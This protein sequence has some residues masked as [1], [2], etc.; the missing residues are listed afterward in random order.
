MNFL[1]KW[2]HIIRNCS[3]DNT[4]KMAWAKAITEISLE[5]DYNNE[6]ESI[7]IT[8]EQI[9]NKVL[10][11]YWEQTIYF[12]LI[13][14]S[15]PNKP[16]KI[17]SFTKELIDKYQEKVG[18]KKPK[19]FYKSMVETVCK[20]DYKRTIGKIVTGLKQDVSYRFLNLG[21]ENIESVYRYNRGDDKLV[22]SKDNLLE[23][24]RNYQIVFDTINYRWT[25]I[26]E[27]FN[28]SPR[29]SKKIKVIDLDEVKRR[30]LGKFKGYIGYENQDNICFICGE[31]IVGETPS[32]DHIIPWSYLY[33]DNLWNL[34]FTHRSCNS[35]KSNTIPSEETIKRL[36]ERN[37]KL[38]N[39]LKDKGIGDKVVYDLE[40]AIDGNLV[41]KF[42]VSC[43]Y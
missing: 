6:N 13:Q 21:R 40:N 5:I 19:K 39:I 37:I 32:I 14:G 23:L 7:E 2:L 9:A 38:L 33:D 29:I 43:Q 22:I 8:L 17:L 41:R 1:D 27:G 18:S 4:Y 34:V 16:P 28:H 10:K 36:E 24:N 3:V 30:P 42:W 31:R 25:S 26:L 20:D 12:N 15:N 35:S 11:Y